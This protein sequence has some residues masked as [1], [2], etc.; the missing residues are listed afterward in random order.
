MTILQV[1]LLLAQ[2]SRA[3]QDAHDALVALRLHD[4]AT[5]VHI[6]GEAVAL[7]VGMIVKSEAEKR[8]AELAGVSS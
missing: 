6:A 3:L 8:R 4:I 7:A 5:R 1:L 2:A